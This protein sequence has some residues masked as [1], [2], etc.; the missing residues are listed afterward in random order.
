MSLKPT[1]TPITTALDEVELEERKRVI[2]HQ[3][4]EEEGRPEGQAEQHW[5][6]ACIV[7]MNYGADL[8]PFETPQ[9]PEWLRPQAE[10]AAAKN[11]VELP[12]PTAEPTSSIDDIRK[13]VNQRSAA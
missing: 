8:Q 6:R 3:I 9:E 2:A 5:E 10:V 7:V 13:R 1:Q 12:R 4:W 11:T